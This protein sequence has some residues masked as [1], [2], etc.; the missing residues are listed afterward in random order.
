MQGQITLT[1]NT[2][3]N[4]H[5]HFAVNSKVLFFLLLTSIFVPPEVKRQKSVPEDLKKAE[6][7]R[8]SPIEVDIRRPFEEEVCLFFSSS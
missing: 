6:E 7:D 1:N 5:V 4:P 2:F 8:G 3:L